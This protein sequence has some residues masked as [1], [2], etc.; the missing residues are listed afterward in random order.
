[1]LPN[2]LRQ[3]YHLTIVGGGADLEYC[4]ELVEKNELSGNVSFTGAVPNSEVYKYLAKS[5]VFVLLSENE[6][7]P[8][9][10]IE[11]LRAGLAVI[12]TNVSGIPELVSNN[13]GVLIKPDA[14]EFADV[15]ATDK[16]DWKQMGKNSRELFEKKYTFDRM[17]QDYV[18]MVKSMWS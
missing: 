2:V 1:M 15:L 16:L 8:I 18:D 9:S 12:S 11:A 5:D 4:K 14:R 7:L 13:N 6:G 17:R 10:I 3:K